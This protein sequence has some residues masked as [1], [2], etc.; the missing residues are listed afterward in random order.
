[1]VLTD[2]NADGNADIY[3]AQNFFSP[4]LETGRMDGGVSLLLL[5]KGDGTF[6]EVW[7]MGADGEPRFISL[8]VSVSRHSS[9]CNPTTIQ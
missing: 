6:Q 9:W 3:I 2:V 8:R 5:G 4:Q 7:P 1:M